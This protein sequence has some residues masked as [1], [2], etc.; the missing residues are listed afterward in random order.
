MTDCGA[1]LQSPHY[2]WGKK[3]HTVLIILKYMH[4]QSVNSQ[5]I[6][7]YNWNKLF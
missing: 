4:N 5:N 6:K 7:P 2:A 1:S 3:I